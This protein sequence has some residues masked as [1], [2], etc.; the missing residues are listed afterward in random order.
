MLLKRFSRRI[1]AAAYFHLPRKRSPSSTAEGSKAE[2]KTKMKQLGVG[3]TNTC[4]RLHYI[5]DCP[6]PGL[7]GET[8][9]TCGPFRTRPAAIIVEHMMISAKTVRNL[10]H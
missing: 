10:K 8:P 2:Q 5:F 1:R 4:G 3:L 9:G 7:N 6:R